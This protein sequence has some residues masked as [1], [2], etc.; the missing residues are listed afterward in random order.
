MGHHL[1]GPHL[2]RGA[3]SEIRLIQ[4]K[5][6]WG[7]LV[8]NEVLQA[9]T[10]VHRTPHSIRRPSSSKESG[11]DKG[12]SVFPVRLGMFSAR[13]YIHVGDRFENQLKKKIIKNDDIGS[14]R[15]S[16]QTPPNRK[17]RTGIQSVTT[18]PAAIDSVYI[19]RSEFFS[20]WMLTKTHP[21]AGYKRV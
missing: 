3:P 6:A 21:A 18:P 2:K 19:D 4:V 11:Y 7:A 16:Q 15:D 13:S 12:E 9:V 1:C 5:V 14:R 17:A 8:L 20:K 10:D